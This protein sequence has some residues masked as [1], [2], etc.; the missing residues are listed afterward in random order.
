MR[1]SLIALFLFVFS[2]SMI[3]IAAD[4]PGEDD[5]R[6]MKLA[7]AQ[8]EALN[9]PDRDEC[10]GDGECEELPLGEHKCGGPSRYIVYS[11]N[12]SNAAIIKKLAAD[13]TA[14]EKGLNQIEMSSVTCGNV[15]TPDPKCVKNKCVDAK[16]KK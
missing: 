16:A 8:I 10:I 15:R 5:K 3:A 4:E 14:A 6:R 11:T 13:Y 2:K 7:L 9:K 1:T 12:N